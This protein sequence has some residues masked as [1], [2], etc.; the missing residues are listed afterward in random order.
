M[1]YNNPGY[2][3]PYVSSPNMGMPQMYGTPS[4][5]NNPMT[6]Q[7]PVQQQQPQPQGNLISARVVSNPDEI[8]PQEIPMDGTTS[9]FMQSD[10]SCV[11]AKSLD[12][13]GTIR[14]VRYIPEPQKEQNNQNG[15]N[16][17]VLVDTDMFEDIM[18]NLNDI[19]DLLKKRPYYP[20]NQY[21]KNNNRNHTVNQEE[22]NA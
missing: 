12:K 3:Y 1:Y 13:D 14:T 7:V 8:T 18:D 6:P 15:T 19:K 20:K 22:N 4:Y 10:A 17:A 21:R 11:Y 5:P 16:G 2:T 9:L